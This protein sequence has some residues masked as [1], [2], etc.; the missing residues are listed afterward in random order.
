MKIS[1]VQIENYRNLRNVDVTLENI[2]TLIGKKDKYNK[3][4][5]LNFFRQH[6]VV[7]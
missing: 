1:R 7:E 5:I 2:V 3:V 6:G 4:Y